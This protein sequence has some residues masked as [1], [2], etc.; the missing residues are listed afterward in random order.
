[1]VSTGWFLRALGPFTLIASL[2]GGTA[3]ADVIASTST[4]VYETESIRV[5]RIV[6]DLGRSRLVLTNL[7]EDGNR[8]APEAPDASPGEPAGDESRQAGEGPVETSPATDAEPH[9]VHVDL[10]QDGVVRI[11]DGNGTTIVININPPPPPP[12]AEAAVL[13][14]VVR[15]WIAYGGAIGRYE[16]PENHPFLGYTTGIDSPG[17]MGGLGLNAGN[18]YG[19]GRGGRCRGINCMFAPGGSG[20]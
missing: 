13:P 20:R 3:A 19:L 12:V 4:V 14:V 1:M 2:G 15:P 17:W 16:F 6:D 5:Y 9:E 8:L 7:D 18:G 10:E 11:D